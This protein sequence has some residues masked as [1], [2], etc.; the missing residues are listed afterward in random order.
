M[1][2]LIRRQDDQNRESHNPDTERRRSLSFLSLFVIDAELVDFDGHTC[3]TM[4]HFQ[5]FL[6]IAKDDSKAVC[7]RTL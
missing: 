2:D 5:V 1:V 7:S 3:P 4:R 6:V